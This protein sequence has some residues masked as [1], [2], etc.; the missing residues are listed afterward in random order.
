MNLLSGPAPVD[1]MG[2]REIYR[3][4]KANL[5]EAVIAFHA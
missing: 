3:I 5:R 1:E 2:G 4:A